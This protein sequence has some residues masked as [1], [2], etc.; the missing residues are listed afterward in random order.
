MRGEGEERTRSLSRFVTLSSFQAAHI[1]LNAKLLAYYREHRITD[2]IELSMKVIGGET[3]GDYPILA[4]AGIKGASIRALVPWAA[5]LASELSAGSR[6]KMR[7]AKIWT[8]LLSIYRV[9][10]T[11]GMFLDAGALTELRGAIHELVINYVYVARHHMD[12][13][14]VRYNLVYKFHYLVHL[15]DFA[16]SINPHRVSTYT[17]ESFVAQGARLWN[18]GAFGAKTQEAV[19]QKYLIALQLKLYLPELVV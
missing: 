10:E 13:G 16:A 1:R 17:E 11:G 18:H 5:G 19:L 9:L 8:A 6:V 15:G 14:N 2:R 3:H 7:R 4:G 12:R